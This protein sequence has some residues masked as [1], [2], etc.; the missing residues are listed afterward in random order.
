MRF[1]TSAK[2]ALMREAAEDR[3]DVAIGAIEE[4]IARREQSV[5]RAHVTASAVR[6]HG[7]IKIGI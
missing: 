4:A 7:R 5:T 2:A 6:F 1:R 3:L